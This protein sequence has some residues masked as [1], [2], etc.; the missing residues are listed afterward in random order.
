[1]LIVA[2]IIMTWAAFAS[3]ETNL[4]DQFK[5][6]SDQLKKDVQ[7]AIDQTSV[8][9]TD[10]SCNK[11]F[12]SVNNYCCE[13]L[14]LGTCCNWYKYVTRNDEIWKNT[15][16]TVNNPRG[17]N[18]I[19]GVSVGIIALLIIGLVIQLICCLCCGC[20]GSKKYVIVG[21]GD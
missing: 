13:V 14:A 16:Y 17:I 10:E 20:C 6:K 19:I 8:C 7:N 1:M 2:L 5:D 12:F 9:M 3:A 11:N 18:I 4:L 21:R 15:V